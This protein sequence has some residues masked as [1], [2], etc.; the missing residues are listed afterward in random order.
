MSGA[1]TGV[2]NINS[3]LYINSSGNVLIG[4]TT[5]KGQKLQVA[6]SILA[7]L[8]NNG[9]VLIGHKGNTIDG[10]ANGTL[11]DLH[12]NY[13]SSGNLTMCNGGG[14]VGIGTNSPSYKLHIVGTAYATENIIAAGDLTAGSDIRYKDKI[15]DLRLSVHDIALA[16]AF[17]YKWNNREDDALVHIGSSAQYWLN[18]DAK[19]AVYYDKQNDFYHLNYASLALCNTIILAR[20]METQEEKIARLEERIKELEDKLRQY[21]CNR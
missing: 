13:K 14:N 5:D 8:G 12:L 20:G 4:A 9:G 7:D 18:T 15:Q 6:G 16:P 19:D 3:S 17:T 11:T 10:Y 1:L 2:T 21:G